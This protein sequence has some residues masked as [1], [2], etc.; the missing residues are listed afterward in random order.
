MS[1]LHTWVSGLNTPELD[2]FRMIEK[3]LPGTVVTFI[4]ASVEISLPPTMAYTLVNIYSEAPGGPVDPTLD[5]VRRNLY[6]HASAMPQIDYPPRVTSSLGEDTHHEGHCGAL[7][8]SVN[9]LGNHIHHIAGRHNC[10]RS[11][12]HPEPTQPR[13]HETHHCGCGKWFGDVTETRKR[14]T[15]PT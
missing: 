8:R 5:K 13:M 9:D 7:M 14:L 3:W 10:Q 1:A 6:R 11:K 4:Y 15:Y 2:A 12:G